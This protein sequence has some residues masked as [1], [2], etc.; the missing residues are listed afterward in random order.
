MEVQAIT[1]YLFLDCKEGVGGARDT[2]EK[3]RLHH[4]QQPVDE[5]F[6]FGP[7]CL[8]PSKRVLL[9]SH[10]PVELGGR[11]FDILTLL[12]RH[13]G[14]VVGRRQILD[15]VWPGLT[16]DESNL[17]VQMSE[18]RRVLRARGKG[19]AYI[20]NV[21]ARGYVFVAPARR[22]RAAGAPTS[23]LARLPEQPKFLLGRDDAIDA[24]VS[25]TLAR[26]FV[27]IVG[28]GAS[29]KTVLAVE[30]GRRLA[31]EF[32]NEVHYVDLGSVRAQNLVLPSIARA[33]GY[34]A[35]SGDLLPELARFA[36]DRRL[37][38]IVDCCE[39]VID[40]AANVL[41]ALFHHVPQMHLIATSREPLRADGETVYF[42]NPL[43]LPVERDHISAVEAL[44][45]ASVS[46]LMRNAAVGGY[47][48]ELDR[49]CAPAAAEICRRLD[50]NPLGIE[51]AGRRLMEYGFDGVLDGVRNGAVLTWQDQRQEPRHRTL[52]AMLDWSFRLL[53]EL[54]RRVLIRLSVLPGAFTM[55]AAQAVASDL[56]DEPSIVAQVVEDLTDKSL[57]G[58]VPLDDRYMYRLPH[59]TRLHVESTCARSIEHQQV[60]TPEA[61]F[62]TKFD[63]F[64]P[65]SFDPRYA[66]IARREAGDAR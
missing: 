11:A 19:S 2:E 32:N 16:V 49:N 33:L 3:P 38:L 21:Q 50:G 15:Q 66:T 4:V 61:A 59:L 43:G 29:G 56:I 36:G 14:E 64:V 28:P 9:A 60:S 37:L 65:R 24:L 12:L 58:I 35:Q 39:H 6:E 23:P 41:A 47:E 26:R 44:A 5:V 31:G 30:V 17:R 10:I 48:R 1:R 13:H 45:S 8:I 25:R 52:A 57:V 34:A 27:T 40:V 55:Q 20:K 46:L 7:Y 42:L 53:S 22:A 63:F 18:L 51:L 62:S 54:E